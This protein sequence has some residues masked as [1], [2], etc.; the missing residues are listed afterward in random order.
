MREAYE[1]QPDLPWTARASRWR[2][3]T[4]S[5]S[6]T[7]IP[8]ANRY[9][10]HHNLPTLTAGTNFT[11]Y[12]GANI[13]EVPASDP[14]GPQGWFT[15]I[16]LDVDAVHSMAPG[17]NIVYSGG[18][19]CSNVDLESAVYT[20]VDGTA[21]VGGPLAD[22]ITNSY[23]QTGEGSSPA[24]MAVE[25]AIFEQADVEGVSVL[26]SSGDNGDVAYEI[27]IADASYP[28]SDP[29]VTAGWRPPR[30][31]CATRMASSLSG[32]GGTFRAYLNGVTE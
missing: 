9:S 15:E 23:G 13:K 24:E 17:A 31:R 32:A 20:V 7:L 12:Y 2:S 19:S 5:T 3:S 8:D 11:Q 21:T 29:L 30:W 22:I 1:L 18:L 6:P 10:K 16:S 26:F 25:D 14:C 27:G 28:A 4:P